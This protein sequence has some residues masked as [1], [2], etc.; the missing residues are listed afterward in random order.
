MKKWKL[1]N[2]Y[3]IAK[4]ELAN[5]QEHGRKSFFLDM[6]DDELA[7]WIH[8][9]IQP[10]TQY[11]HKSNVLVGRPVPSLDVTFPYSN[12]LRYTFMSEDE[13]AP[14][15]PYMTQ[16]I[17][18]TLTNARIGLSVHPVR[19]PVRDHPTNL[20]IVARLA[21]GMPVLVKKNSDNRIHPDDTLG[22][23]D[24]YENR[25]LSSIMSFLSFGV[26]RPYRNTPQNHIALVNTPSQND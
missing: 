24:I 15:R 19:N 9:A 16:S 17:L 7:R 23:D 21:K 18:T 20:A 14:D 4:E 25:E 6:T 26:Y 12:H 1:S 10:L 8:R 5:R 3:R 2:Q 22:D 13:L 11:M